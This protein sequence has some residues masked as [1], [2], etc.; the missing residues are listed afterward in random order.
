M[1]RLGKADRVGGRS[2]EEAGGGGWS[3]KQRALLEG[4]RG[5][6]L[7][8]N[9]FSITTGMNGADYRAASEAA[10]SDV[11]AYQRMPLLFNE[12]PTG[13]PLEACVSRRAEAIG[14]CH[15]IGVSANLEIVQVDP[16]R[17]AEEGRSGW[18]V[19]SARSNLDRPE[20]YRPAVDVTLYDVDSA[21]VA[22]I[23]ASFAAVAGGGMQPSVR[24]VLRE[25]LR[26]PF[27]EIRPG[28]A[29]IEAPRSFDVAQALV[30]ETWG[31]MPE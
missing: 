4:A 19:L 15:V 29:V 5:I 14:I 7:M 28:E 10:A 12:P 23:R 25:K 31:K 18:L 6:H 2:G 26:N 1:F 17:I 8:L 9:G 20:T 21:L 22:A 24:A 11:A 30:F 16:A 3:A 13:Q 27:G